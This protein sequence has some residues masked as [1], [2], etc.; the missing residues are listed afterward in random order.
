MGDIERGHGGGQS[1][2]DLSTLSEREREVLA[3]A[4]DGLSARAMAEGLSLTEATVRSH[5]SRI[6]AKL[7][8]AGRVELLAKLNGGSG[9]NVLPLSPDPT[10]AARQSP[11]RPRRRVFAGLLLG[12]AVA[13][14]ALFAWLRPDLP[15]RTD[16]AAVAQLVAEKKVT[17][18]DLVADTLL[19][20]LADGQQ[21]RVDGV[22]PES[23]E[24]IQA[25][26]I[27][28]SDR[29]SVSAG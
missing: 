4:L 7:G 24:P 10:A 20:T 5:L 13:L 29:V 28:A 23:V 6:Y 2:A 25:A 3:L 18:L 22:D 19:V 9:R 12:L 16:L 26:A 21:L 1:D 11:R 27:A 8:V 15:R 17:S 14:G